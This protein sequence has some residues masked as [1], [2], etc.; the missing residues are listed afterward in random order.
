M[1]LQVKLLAAAAVLAVSST[2]SFAVVAPD[3]DLGT[4][5]KYPVQF[6]GSRSGA[7]RVPQP[8]DRLFSHDYTFTLGSMAS[9]IG[10]VSNFFGETSFSSVTVTSSGGASWTKSLTDTNDLSFDFANL[11]A[12]SYKLTVGGVF[13]LGFHAYSGSVYAATAPVPEPASLALALAGLGV[14]AGVARRRGPQA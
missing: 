9:V 13:P 1:K 5:T 12:G 8:G 10:S 2:S 7:E 4:L 14:V 11:A 6:G 3:E